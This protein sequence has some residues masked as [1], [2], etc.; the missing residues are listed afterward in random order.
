MNTVTGDKQYVKVKAS[1]SGNARLDARGCRGAMASL[2]RHL[3]VWYVGCP[4]Q[5]VHITTFPPGMPISVGGP[6]VCTIFKKSSLPEATLF[7]EMMIKAS[8]MLSRDSLARIQQ[9]RENKTSFMI[10]EMRAE[11]T[12]HPQSQMHTRRMYP[13]LHCQ[14]L[15]GRNNAWLTPPPLD[16]ARCPFPT[17]VDRCLSSTPLLPSVFSSSVPAL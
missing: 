10:W 7:P 13:S 16:Y 6:S 9:H 5:P 3:C 15:L 8:C 14:I 11:E 1:R 12:C 2:W 4:A 17:P